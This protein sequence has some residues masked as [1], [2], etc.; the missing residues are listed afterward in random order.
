MRAVQAENWEKVDAFFRA[1]G[2]DPSHPEVIAFKQSKGYIP[3]TPSAPAPAQPP[4]RQ[5]H[6]NEPGDLHL[7]DPKPGFTLVQEADGR[8]YTVSTNRHG[9]VVKYLAGGQYDFVSRAGVVTVE[10]F[11]ETGSTH[12]ALAGLGPVDYAGRAFFGSNTSSRGVMRRWDNGSGHFMQGAGDTASCT[13]QA[14]LP[15]NLFDPIH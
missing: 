6:N 2:I 7:Q 5:F 4:A 10:G 14:G 13:H 11:M 3:G 1:A 9:Q 8:W 12:T 15:M